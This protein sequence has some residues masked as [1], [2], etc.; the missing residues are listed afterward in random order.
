MGD[1]RDTVDV[2]VG[3]AVAVG[4]RV[5][6]ADAVAYETIHSCHDLFPY[7]NTDG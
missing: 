6:V 3:I 4:V 7:L 5:R 2:R 1:G